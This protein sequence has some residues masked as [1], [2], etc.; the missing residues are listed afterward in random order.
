MG[1]TDAT[2]K[3]TT[4]ESKESA[5]MD[6]AA[7]EAEVAAL[8]KQI[9]A[10]IDEVDNNFKLSG[11]LKR[12]KRKELNRLQATRNRLQKQLNEGV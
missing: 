3:A 11:P 1:A 2:A 12:E 6:K 7:T 8:S 10:A 4:E 9:E 5:P